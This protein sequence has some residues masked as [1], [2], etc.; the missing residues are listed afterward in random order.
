MK[1]KRTN[2]KKPPE[3]LPPPQVA[4][5]YEVERRWLEDREWLPF[6][7]GS[8]HGHRYAT[9][10]EAATVAKQLAPHNAGV[11]VIRVMTIREAEV[12]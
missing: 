6:T 3:P 11:R 2:T 4:I 9:R 12:P 7:Q 10:A 1:T 8:F 5:H